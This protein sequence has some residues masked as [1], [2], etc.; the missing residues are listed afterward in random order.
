MSAIVFSRHAREKFRVLARHS[1]YISEDEVK[2]VIIDP[3]NVELGE[4][5]RFIAQ[6]AINERHVLR[7][8]YVKKENGSCNILS[9]KEGKI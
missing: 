4:K 5:G 7:V 3:D 8:I 1:L 9:C 2:E 6:K